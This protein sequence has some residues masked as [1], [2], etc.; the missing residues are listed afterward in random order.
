VPSRQ[1]FVQ[2]IQHLHI[3]KSEMG[4][5]RSTR[6]STFE[7]KV[8]VCLHD[9]HHGWIAAKALAPK[10]DDSQKFIPHYSGKILSNAKKSACR[11][12]TMTGN[13]P[14]D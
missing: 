8:L 10:L 7:A 2:E 14:V 1:G 3:D 11:C 12:T 13:V 9:S 6:G 5:K 4:V